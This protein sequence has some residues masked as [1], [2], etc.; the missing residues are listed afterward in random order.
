MRQTAVEIRPFF[1]KHSHNQ[2]ASASA[3]YETHPSSQDD[4]H[5]TKLSVQLFGPMQLQSQANTVQ[6]EGC[7]L[8]VTIEFA[9]E[10]Q[11]VLLEQMPIVDDT[12]KL[13]REN[14]PTEAVAQ[15]QTEN[16][17]KFIGNQ[18]SVLMS[19]ILASS[20]C[21]DEYNGSQIMC[22]FQVIELDQDIV[23]A[24][25]QALAKALHHSTFK[26]RC[27]PVGVTI[28]QLVDGTL[29]VDPALK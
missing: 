28:L 10:N 3:Y 7:Q 12:L 22:T 16:K 23:Q 2:S 26:L 5:G 14:M 8:K 18:L 13:V 1:T 29:V 11:R 27:L 15:M 21:T 19:Q 25:V 4:K 20:L 6:S 9:D 17:L 24:M